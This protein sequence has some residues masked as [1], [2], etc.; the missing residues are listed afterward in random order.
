[1]SAL[2]RHLIERRRALAQR[3]LDGLLILAAVVG[4]VDLVAGLLVLDEV[5]QVVGALDRACR[6]PW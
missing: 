5:G 1:V 2:W 4:Q 6:R 3:D